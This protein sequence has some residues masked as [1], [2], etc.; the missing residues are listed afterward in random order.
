MEFDL[1][2]TN[3]TIIDGTGRPRFR[4]EVGI[5]DGRIAEGQRA[6]LVL[7]DPETVADNTTAERAG[8]WWSG[9]DNWYKM[10]GTVWCCGG[11]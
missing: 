8:R 6:D 1:V 2:I 10:A 5:R 9:T 4:A 7:F 3:G 11:S